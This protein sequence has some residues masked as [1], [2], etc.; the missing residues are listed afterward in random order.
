MANDSLIP[1]APL[2][3]RIQS[4][5]FYL[6]LGIAFCLAVC[7]AVSGLAAFSQQGRIR[8]EDRINPNYAPQASL[9]RLPGIGDGRAKAIVDYRENFSEETAGAFRTCDDLQKIRGIGPKTAA[10]ICEYLKFE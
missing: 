4:F 5:A 3:N 10:G 7:F 2:Q 8:L 1:K 9:I 6:A